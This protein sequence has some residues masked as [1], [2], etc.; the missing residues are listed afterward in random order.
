MNRKIEAKILPGI[1]VL[2]QTEEMVRGKNQPKPVYDVGADAKFG[3]PAE[4]YGDGPK[5]EVVKGSLADRVSPM[6]GVEN[7]EGKSIAR[8]RPNQ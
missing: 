2:E 7:P 5:F 6:G 1:E 8:K 4:M 3:L